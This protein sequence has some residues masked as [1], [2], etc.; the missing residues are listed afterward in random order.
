[1]IDFASVARVDLV[2]FFGIGVLGGAHCIGMCGPVVSMYDKARTDGGSVGSTRDVLYHHGLFNLGRTTSYALLGGLFG[3]LGGLLY[4]TADTLLAVTNVLRG[5]VGVALGVLIIVHGLSS[6]FGQHTSVLQRL[7]LP[8]VSIGRLLN[9][10][11]TRL[12]RLA[13]GPGIVGLGL[14]H[15]LVPCPMLYAAFVYVFAVGSPVVGIAALAAFGLGTVPAVFFYGTTLGSFDT[16]RT[17]RIHRLL[18]AIFVALG[19]VLLA[20]GLMA[21]GIHLPHPELPHYLPT[22]LG[23]G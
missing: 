10:A 13:D 3:A 23:R 15:G 6:A 4:L 20:H 1:M 17:G 8:G 2:L 19:Y 12:T 7:P 22:E 11:S 9:S 21:L 16:L 18:G 14:L 5:T